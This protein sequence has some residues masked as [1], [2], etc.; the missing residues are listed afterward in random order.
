M[1]PD[2]AKYGRVLAAPTRARLMANWSEESSVYAAPVDS[3]S[4]SVKEMACGVGQR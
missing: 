1:G 4:P 3:L 2:P